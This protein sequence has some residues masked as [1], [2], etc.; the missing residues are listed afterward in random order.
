MEN[1]N[2]PK[3]IIMK[4]TNKNGIPVCQAREKRCY[5]YKHIVKRHL[6]DIKE[7]I[8]RSKNDM[9]RNYYLGRYAVQL[10]IYA[11]A[12]DVQEKYLERCI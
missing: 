5:Y 8:K 11:K 2:F 6:R 3:T 10:S 4:S 9:E 12:L 7:N 1:T